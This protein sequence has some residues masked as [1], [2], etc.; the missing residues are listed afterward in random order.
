MVVVPSRLQQCGTA[1]IVA[2]QRRKKGAVS[3]EIGLR[4]RWAAGLLFFSF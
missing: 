3:V 4:G 1:Q 2:V